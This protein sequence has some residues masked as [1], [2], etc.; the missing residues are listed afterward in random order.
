[1]SKVQLEAVLKLIDVQINPQVFRKIS[2]AVA[3]MPVSLQLTNTALKNTGT[4]ANVLNSRLRQTGQVLTNNERAAKLLLNRMAQ[5]AILLPTFATLNHALQGSI[6]FLFEFDSILGDIVRT[7]VKGLTNRMEEIGDAALKTAV[8]LGTTAQEVLS[9]TKV[10]IQAGLSIEESQKRARLAIL[11]TQVSTLDS[12]DAVEF[13]LSAANQFGLA[14]DKLAASLDALV[15]VEDLSAVEARDVAEAFR[16]GGNS[17]AEFGKDINDSIGLISALREQTRKSGREIGTFFK[18]LQTRIFAAGE[19]RSALENLGVSVENLDGSLRPTLDVLNDMKAAFAGLTEAQTANAAKA[20]GGVRQFE[21]LIATLNSLDRA[22]ELSSQA[23]SAA[24]SVD[25]KRIITDQ[26]LERQLGKLIAQGQA[27]AEAFGDAGLEDLLRNALQTATGLLKVFTSLVDT[28]GKLGGNLAPLLALGG[29]ALGKGVFGLS[30]GGGGSGA[31]RPG[32]T[33]F[34]GPTQP[35]RG[36]VLAD[37]ATQGLKQLGSAAANAGKLVGNFGIGI[38]QNTTLNQKQGLQINTNIAGLQTHTNALRANISALGGLAKSTTVQAAAAFK[39]TAGMVALTAAAAVLPTIVQ[40]I[41]DR[42]NSLANVLPGFGAQF[43]ATGTGIVGAGASLAT[44]FALLGPKAAGVA[45]IFGTLFETATRFNAAWNENSLAVEEETTL[46]KRRANIKS[47][48][49][50]ISGLGSGDTDKQAANAFLN[51][52]IN[53]VQG[54]NIGPK[55]NAAITESLNLTSQAE[56]FRKLGL[57]GDDLRESLLEDVFTLERIVTINGPYLKTLAEQ[58]GTTSKLTELQKGL[59]DKTLESA[60]ALRLF[61]EVAGAGTQKFNKAGRREQSFDEFKDTQK[62]IDL[63]KSIRT[64]GLELELAKVGPDDLS[65]S[66]VRLTNE[67]LL[68][69]RE[70]TETSKDLKNKLESKLGE[71]TDF[72]FMNESGKMQTVSVKQFFDIINSGIQDLNPDKIEEFNRFLTNIGPIAAKNANEIQD[73]IKDRLENEKKLAELSLELKKEESNRAK[74]ILESQ[75]QATINAFESVRNFTSELLKF[76]DAVDKDVLKAF[77]S[78]STQDVSNVLSGGSDLSEGLQQII[79]SAFGDDKIGNQLAK[80]NTNLNAI[81]DQTQA[82]LDILGKKLEFVNSKIANT[83]NGSEK[84]ALTNEKLAIEL[85]M[86]ETIN[87]GVIASTEAKIKVLEAERDV[88]KQVRE[89]EEKRVNLL[90]KL[91]DASRKFDKEIRDIEKGFKD[92]SEKKMSELLGKEADAQNALKEAQQNVLESTRSLADAYDVLQRAQLDFGGVIAEARIKN[93]LL[94]RD[95]AMLTG[96]ITTFSGQLST[97]NVA[98]KSVLNDSN[99]TL[100]KRIELER[101]LADETLTFLQQARDSIVQAGLGVFGQSGAENREL[102]QGIQGLQFVADQLGGSFENFLRLTQG[103]LSAVTQT[104]LGLPV[105]FRQQIL[106]AI[107]FLP[108]TASIGGFSVD[109]LKQAIGQVGAGVSPESGLPSIEELNKQ[110]VEQLQKIQELTLQDA[111]LQFGQVIT[112]QEQVAKAQEAVDAT[113]LLELRA[114]E[115]LEMVRQSI[116]EEAAVLEVANSERRELLNAVIAADDRNSLMQIER[117]A[118]MFAEQNA[119]F[120]DIGD[121]I[122]QGVSSAINARVA[123]IEAAQNVKSLS[124]GFIPN[125]AGGNL[126]PNEAAGLLRAGAREKKAMPNGAGLAVA[127]TSEAIIPMHNRGYIPNFQDGNVGTISAG[128]SAIQD[129][130]AAVVAAIARSVT[131][132]LS[133]VRSD[134]GAPTEVLTEILA[135]LKSLNDSNEQINTNIGT[136][137]SNTATDATSTAATPATA[138]G[139]A[140]TI[141]LQTQQNSNINV[142]GLENLHAEIVAAVKEAAS[143]QV[144]EQ[145]T[146]LLLELD[147]VITALQER[148]L[149]TGF[150]QPR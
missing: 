148:G 67:L 105:E 60:A 106:D 23:A 52:F 21:S 29:V 110:Q 44:Q 57:S 91:A 7:D 96:G 58:L 82:Q 71:L 32:Q 64:L 83:S 139:Q 46:N 34:V 134:S 116:I 107:S 66:V 112:A 54:V 55:L 1:M 69:K 18:T 84:L 122:V 138:T 120:R 114:V 41:E 9:T 149:L 14:G 27:F 53:A 79:L 26:K 38:L 86:E 76:G 87:R 75:T 12:V 136:V 108:S 6:K 39:G 137:A 13:F 25:E 100:Q 127:N 43:L 140:V 121:I 73:I 147:N 63:G 126:T 56:A 123:T 113:K 135:E 81:T 143:D 28:V 131:T 144:D 62:V 109:Q 36:S 97:L 132:A 8:D 10:F 50:V 99:M 20:I 125:F 51:N 101:Q 111:Q 119:T 145:L 17:L 11:A 47:G 24:G 15:K 118:E 93:N 102:G 98:F 19:A 103:E 65:D 16:T 90:E 31:P 142:S 92:F 128:I 33:G 80:A 59:R 77:Q 40:K 48:S 117:E 88:E 133:E 22:N 2:Q 124:K 89:E 104:L 141:T 45:G 146:S 4:Q 68:L 95:I 115:S 72:S 94:S 78:V 37:T 35:S 150:I 74:A 130:N 30:A 129:I 85:S 3:G 42:F 49:L 5:F 70:A 61:A